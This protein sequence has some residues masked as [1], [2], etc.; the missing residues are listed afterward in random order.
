M[1]TLKRKG[2]AFKGNTIGLDLHQAFIEEVVLDPNGDD[3]QAKRIAPKKE[4]LEKLLLEWKAKGD[5]QV[6]FEACGCFFWVFELATR[7]LGRER[8]HVAHAGR[9]AMIANSGEKNDHNDAWWLAYLLQDRRLPE[10]YVA[11]GDLLELRIAGRELRYY[12]DMRSDLVRRVRSSLAQ[13]GEKLPKG[14]H[15]SELKRAKAKAL[16]ENIAGMRGEA[17]RDLYAEIERLSERIASWR[18]KVE[19]LCKAFP[20]IEVMMRELPGIK[21]VTAGLMYGELGSP[22]RYHS[23]KA[24]GK[25]T[26]ITPSFRESGGKAQASSITRQGSRLAR[27][28]LTRAVISCSRCTKNEAGVQVKKWVAKQVAR[29]KP[30][31]KVIVAAARKMAEGIWRLMAWGEM[32]DLKRAFPT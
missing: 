29:N 3:V 2:K 21:V 16:L 24:Y 13:L 12:T 17:L 31:R 30:K 28:A 27:W 8:V 9:I 1:K 7:I 14:W 26:G 6:V 23:A 11:E 15:T 5:L 25:A 32:F 22:K 19:K 20:E 4:A 18:K 10:A